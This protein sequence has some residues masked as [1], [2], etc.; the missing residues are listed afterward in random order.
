MRDYYIFKNG[1]LKRK[2]NTLCYEYYEDG[3]EKRFFIPSE[4]VDAIWIFAESEL[5]THLIHF[6][7]QN[8]IAVHFFNYYGWYSGSFYP[9]EFLLSGEVTVRQVE[10]YLNE[11]K[12]L[13]IAK[14]FILGG[15]H[16]MI[17]NLKRHSE[18]FEDEIKD[19]EKFKESVGEQMG[20][21]EL[22]GV[23]GNAREKYYS[24]FERILGSKFEFTKR[25]KNPPDNSVNALISFLNGVV[26]ASILKELYKTQLDPTVSYL[27]EPSTRRFSLCLDIAEI[28]KPIFADRILFE[29]LNLGT[30]KKDHFDK[31][32]NYAYLKE[33]GRKIVMKAFDEKMST[34]I[35]H[36]E[37][38]KKV[39]YRRLMKLEAYKLIKHVLGDK[40]Y[41]SLR[42][43]W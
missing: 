16:G 40:P 15:I 42:M 32:L 20:I 3:E 34:T 14:E 5:N 1:R 10:H 21:S 26:Y 41:K 38:G 8:N 30:L 6:L 11:E 22:M 31:D 39:S 24:C 36:K 37:L 9:K 28:F 18:E 2:E 19:L 33:S 4:D 25:V 29:L 23:E 27:H 7:S 43:W 35:F 12:R 17:R 13:F